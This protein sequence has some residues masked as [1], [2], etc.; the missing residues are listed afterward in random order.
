[1]ADGTGGLINWLVETQARGVW[2]EHF[3]E[4]AR[5]DAFDYVAEDE[6]LSPISVRFVGFGKRPKL[7]MKGPRKSNV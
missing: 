1:L 6:V 7:T 2:R 4:I 3:S 5:D